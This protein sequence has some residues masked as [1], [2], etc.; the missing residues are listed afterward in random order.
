MRPVACVLTL[1]LCSFPAPAQPRDAGADGRFSERT[2]S[3]FHLFQ[4]VD[5][6]R[7]H[8]RG[9]SR[10]FERDVLAILEDAYDRV[11]EALGIRPRQRI[12]VVVYDSAVFERQF[13][14]LFGFR[15]A[16]FFNGVIHVRSRQAIDNRLARTLHHEYLHAALH[17]SAAN[18]AYPAWL[19]EGLAELFERHSMGQHRLTRGERHALSEVSRS[20]GWIPLS[21]LGGGSF[22]HLGEDGATLAY[23]EAWAMVEHLARRHGER[24][25]RD[26]CRQLGRTRNAE[27]ALER[28]YSRSLT[29]LEGDLL[30]ELR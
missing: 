20:G 26:L 18:G 15:A 24:S 1:L 6:D 10:S 22:S 3:H 29:E 14:Q 28:V 23:L 19:N 21:R 8:G 9:G 13:G 4:D 7:Y 25:L 27:R 16:G 5:I 17:T 12:R 11:G 30:R 2:S